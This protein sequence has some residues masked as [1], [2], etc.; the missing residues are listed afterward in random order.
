MNGLDR[1]LPSLRPH[2]S[3]RRLTIA[4]VSGANKG[5][6]YANFGSKEGLF[7]AVGGF[8]TWTVKLYPVK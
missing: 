4:S 8:D 6:I 3:A 1:A 5:R 2:E 7:D